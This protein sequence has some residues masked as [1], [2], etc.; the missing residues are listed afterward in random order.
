MSCKMLPENGLQR[1]WCV[2]AGDFPLQNP[3]WQRGDAREWREGEGAAGAKT[4]K[5]FKWETIKTKLN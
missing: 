4:N 2:C 1:E 5:E 3:G